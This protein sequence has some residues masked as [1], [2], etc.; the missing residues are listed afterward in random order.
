MA[1]YMYSQGLGFLI[2][3]TRGVDYIVLKGPSNSDSRCSGQSVCYENK[4]MVNVHSTNVYCILTWWQA[5]G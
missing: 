2:C 3:N 4:H 1:M 5:L